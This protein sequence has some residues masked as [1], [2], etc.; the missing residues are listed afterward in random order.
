MCVKLKRNQNHKSGSSSLPKYLLPLL[1]CEGFGPWCI[2]YC[3]GVG[4][5]S[6]HSAPYVSS[7]SFPSDE[8]KHEKEKNRNNL[9]LAQILAQNSRG[10]RESEVTNLLKRSQNANLCAISDCMH[11]TFFDRCGVVSHERLTTVTNFLIGTL[12]SMFAYVCIC[13]L[14][15][16]SRA[17][18]VQHV[19]VSEDA[20]Y[21]A[22]RANVYRFSVSRFSTTHQLGCTSKS[23]LV[24]LKSRSVNL[25][26]KHVGHSTM[27]HHQW[28]AKAQQRCQLWWNLISDHS[29][30]A[31][32]SL[33]KWIWVSSAGDPGFIAR[34]SPFIRENARLLDSK[35][36]TN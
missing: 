13:C 20:G 11:Q 2:L 15:L 32:S 5:H 8:C 26:S 34:P 27:P 31:D 18:S 24:A 22:I 23:F 6:A 21:V 35:P 1:L 4:A 28:A 19:E 10:P 30:Q 17:K 12:T 7:S 14:L 36:S 3:P 33:D 9:C 29:L 16:N 25:T